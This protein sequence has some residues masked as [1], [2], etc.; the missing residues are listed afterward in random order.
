MELN[1]DICRDAPLGRLD[2]FCKSDR[3]QKVH[4]AK[5]GCVMGYFICFCVDKTEMGD[6][7]QSPIR[8]PI[9]AG[10]DEGATTAFSIWKKANQGNFDGMRYTEKPRLY[11]QRIVAE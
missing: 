4:L 8:I 9:K 5:E 2:F 3:L 7:F 6:S 11:F 1:K 10:S